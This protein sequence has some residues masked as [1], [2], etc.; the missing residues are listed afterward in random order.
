[1]KRLR[2]WAIVTYVERVKED[3]NDP[4]EG[5]F[6]DSPDD[7]SESFERILDLNF[8]GSN[9]E[10]AHP[11][12]RQEEVFVGSSLVDDLEG[13]DLE[14][15]T[16]AGGRQEEVSFDSSLVDDLGG[17]DLEQEDFVGSSLV[18]DF[19]GCDL[20]QE[21]EEEIIIPPSVPKMNIDDSTV[22]TLPVKMN[23]KD[24]E[25]WPTEVEK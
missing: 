14:E 12:G 24:V 18:D 7:R 5:V 8:V 17:S 21:E 10:E 22:F 13:S 11:R 20:E 6:S 4:D 2:G 25:I 23:G 19:G 9:E 3:Q 15:E 16:H 1:V